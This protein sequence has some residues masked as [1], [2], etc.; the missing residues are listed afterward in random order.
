VPLLR[1]VARYFEVPLDHAAFVT[2]VESGSPAAVG[3]I[4]EGDL[5]VRFDETWIHGVDDLHRLLTADQVGKAIPITLIRG[6][7]KKLV[8]VHPKAMNGTQ[9]G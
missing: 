7:E 6:R 5:L 4:K 1:R 3:G 8:T 9:Q 2:Q